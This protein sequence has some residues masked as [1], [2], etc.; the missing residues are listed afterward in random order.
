MEF[1]FPSRA[2]RIKNK[3]REGGREK[4]LRRGQGE[5]S[6]WIYQ[7]PLGLRPFCKQLFLVHLGT[8]TVLLIGVQPAMS[9]L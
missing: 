7:K 8:D 4:R 2:Q 9:E 3:P 1:R 5:F 6:F